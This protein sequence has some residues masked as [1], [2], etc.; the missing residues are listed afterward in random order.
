MAR[1]LT[2]P[3]T[4]AATKRDDERAQARDQGRRQRRDHQEGEGG[5][6]QPDQVGEQQPGDAGRARRSRARPRPRPAAPARPSVAVISR[7]LASARIAVP[8]FVYFRKAAVTR[9]PRRRAR[10]RSPASRLTRPGR[11]RSRSWTVGS[12]IERALSLQIQDISPSRISARPSVAVA[13][14]SGSRRASGGPNSIAVG[15]RDRPRRTAT[16]TSV[17]ERRRPSECVDQVP[18]DQ[19]AHGADRAEGQVQHAGGPVENH[20]PDPGQGVHPAQ[21]QAGDDERLEVL[22]ARHLA[23][24]DAL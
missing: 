16:Q 24:L 9:R 3:I 20:H 18:G 11:R 12:T 14:T 7:S 13:L 2:R 5:R 15:E 6:V 1:A 4:S 17:G 8:S 10:A 23:T 21:G 19:G 22:P